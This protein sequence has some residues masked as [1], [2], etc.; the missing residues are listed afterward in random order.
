MLHLDG[1]RGLA[2]VAVIAFHCVEHVEARSL[3]DRAVRLVAGLGFSGVDLFFALSGLLI[4]S[5]LL[6]QRSRQGFWG[7]S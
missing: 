1:L 4:T 2:A 6:E 3:P 5:L 7:A